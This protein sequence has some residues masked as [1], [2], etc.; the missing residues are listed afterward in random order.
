MIHRLD[1][2]STYVDMWKLPA[3]NNAANRYPI[4]AEPTTAP[5]RPEN[6]YT[7]STMS[8]NTALVLCGLTLGGVRLAIAAGVGGISLLVVMRLPISLSDPGTRFWAELKRLLP[9]AS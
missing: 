8:A 4:T 7:K 6:R 3:L 5:N 1:T 9:S 2:D